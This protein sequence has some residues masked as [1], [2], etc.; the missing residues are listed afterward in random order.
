ML[1]PLW[2]AYYPFQ[3]HDW[4]ETGWCT[5][6]PLG[7]AS[8]HRIFQGTSQAGGKWRGRWRSRQVEGATTEAMSPAPPGLGW[9]GAPA[10]PSDV[11]LAVSGEVSRPAGS[12]LTSCHTCL[13]IFGAHL[14]GLAVLR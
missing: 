8:S 12:E 9:W 10:H 3:G 1:S 4:V 13:L 14:Q 6:S 5:P 11:T 2:A 7:T